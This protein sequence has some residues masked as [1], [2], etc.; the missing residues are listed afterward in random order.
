MVKIL[1]KI[2]VKDC[3]QLSKLFH[4]WIS[5]LC[6]AFQKSL[7]L[8]AIVPFSLPIFKGKSRNFVFNFLWQP[9]KPCMAISL[10]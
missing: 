10:W 6:K 5:F 2:L 4:W 1:V 3:L 7:F 8:L 9:C